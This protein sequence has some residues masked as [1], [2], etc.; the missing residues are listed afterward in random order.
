MVSTA[1]ASTAG[2]IAS[3]RS[4]P[5]GRRCERAA[6]SCSVGTIFPHGL[7]CH[8]LASLR[9]IGSSVSR[10]PCS[11]AGAISPIRLSTHVRFLSQGRTR[12]KDRALRAARARDWRRGAPITGQTVNPVISRWAGT[13]N[14]PCFGRQSSVGR[15]PPWPLKILRPRGSEATSSRLCNVPKRPPGSS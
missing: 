14:S 13:T 4:R 3:V 9:S 12:R 1:S 10:C 7:P 15:I 11:A 5:V 6:I 8:S 2:S